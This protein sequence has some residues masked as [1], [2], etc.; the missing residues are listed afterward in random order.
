MSPMSGSYNPCVTSAPNTFVCGRCKQTMDVKFSENARGAV[1]REATCPA[2]HVRDF[3]YPEFADE[4]A[5]AIVEVPQAI[6]HAVDRRL[7]CPKCTHK[8]NI[9]VYPW[10]H[11]PMCK[12]CAS[13]NNLRG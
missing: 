12:D 5:A 8:T 7:T 10:G 4:S 1:L 6:S 2:C 11:G 3:S 9:F 13:K